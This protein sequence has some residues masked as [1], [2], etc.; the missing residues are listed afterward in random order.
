MKVV[1]IGGTGT[2]GTGVIRELVKEKDV[3]WVGLS[4][5]RID[6]A[7]ELAKELGDKV[8]P[9]Q[10][11]VTEIDKLAKVIK[12]AD[13]ILNCSGPYYKLSIPVIKTVVKE[14][15]DYIDLMDDPDSMMEVLRDAKLNRAA[16]DAGITVIV[17]LGSTPGLS[18][19]LGKYGATKLENVERI[20]VS[21]AFTSVSGT[22]AGTAVSEHM[23]HVMN[24]GWTYIDGKWVEIEPL[25]DGRDTQDFIQL[26]KLD[27]YDIG[28]PE[29]IMLP[30]YIK[31]VKTVTCKAG[32]VPCE[33]LQIYRT[34]SQL[35]L[36]G[37]TPID[38]K[39]VIITPRD[40]VMKHLAKVPM[41]T[42]VK[43]FK[44]DEIE[45]VFELR[46][47]VTGEKDGRKTYYTYNFVDVSHEE[48]T[49]I[50][51]ALGALVL[52]R[53]EVKAKGVF[54]PEGC[55]NPESFLRKVVEKG[56]VLYETVQEKRELFKP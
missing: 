12:G 11:D 56:V 19:L 30:R 28:H 34:L 22:G 9:V 1:V 23:L 18:N 27:V 3:E 32:M 16:K 35:R 13:V 48:G 25:V 14:G 21:W 10:L 31:G 45:P 33:M 46:V 20:D 41:E 38:V 55:I 53:K 40:F 5:R 54:A 15:I 37:L 44:L 17:G 8:S 52:G 29:P 24:K 43:L 39:G 51:T 2:I 7:K 4:S 50:P 42:W 49:Y 36:F 26:G 6:A 47:A